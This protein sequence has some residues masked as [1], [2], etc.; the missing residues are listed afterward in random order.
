MIGGKSWITTVVGALVI[1]LTWANQILVEKGVPA[2]GKDWL[3][4]IIGNAAGL[5]GVFAKD[6]NKSNAPS[7]VAESKPV[8]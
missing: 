7:P 5:I 3:A 6:W 1:V 8:P 4:F 2:S